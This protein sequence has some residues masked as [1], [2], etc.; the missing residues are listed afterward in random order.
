MR[1]A[2][3]TETFLPSIDGVVTRL[4]KGIDYLRQEG[5]EVLVLAPDLGVDEYHGA[6]VQGI[7]TIKLPFYR[8]REFSYPSKK[9]HA[10]LAA[11]KPDIIH[12][13][14]PLLLG[15]SAVS[16]AKKNKIPLLCSYHTHIPKYLNCYGYSLLEPAIWIYLRKMHK[17]AQINL[18][19][20]RA[21][22]KELKDHDIE[23]VYVL[24]RGVDLSHRSPKFFDPQYRRKLQNGNSDKKLLLFVGRLAPEK[25]IHRLLPLLENRED[26]RLIIAGDGPDKEVLMETFKDTDTLFTGFL[27][28]E[29]LSK[30]YASCDAFVFPSVS[31]TLGLVLLEATAS[32]IP[33]LAAKSEPTLEQIADGINGLI[34][35]PDKNED[36]GIQLDRLKDEPLKN[37]II[38]NALKDAEQNSWEYASEQLYHYYEATIQAFEKGYIVEKSFMKRFERTG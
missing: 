29:E 30:L 13:A 20:S 32:G 19:T 8:F 38:S 36:L 28:G 24:K 12:G 37:R 25:E 26:I 21:M 23:N 27:Q 34:F 17:D 3:A 6:K 35:D 22:E 33:V 1:I 16:Y 11:F 9:V 31:E 18:C 10:A 14:N 2:I 4:T 7:P 5:H 15:A